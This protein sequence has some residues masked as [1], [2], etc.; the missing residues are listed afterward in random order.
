MSFIHKVYRY[1]YDEK[2][3]LC[4]VVLTHHVTNLHVVVV[5]TVHVDI[6]DKSTQKKSTTCS[7]CVRI[8]NKP[9]FKLF[10][11]TICL[12]LSFQI[13]DVRPEDSGDYECQLAGYDDDDNNNNSNNEDKVVTQKLE[14]N[15][16]NKADM[17]KYRQAEINKEHQSRQRKHNNHQVQNDQTRMAKMSTTTTTTTQKT[18]STATMAATTTTLTMRNVTWR[19]RHNRR[20]SHHHKNHVESTTVQALGVG[21]RNSGNETNLKLFSLIFCLNLL[22][23]L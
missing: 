9:L 15:V 18:P 4:Y 21:I 17:E 10:F 3:A 12:Y 13:V 14:I 16:F 8:R 6:F 22:W 20:K 11:I 23:L 19:R 5:Y 7:I 2:F 1:T